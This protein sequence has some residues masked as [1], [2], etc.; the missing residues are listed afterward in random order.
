[1][2]GNSEEAI[3]ELSGELSET[4]AQLLEIIVTLTKTRKKLAE[5]PLPARQ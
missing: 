1:M 2:I 5:E 4:E 3:S